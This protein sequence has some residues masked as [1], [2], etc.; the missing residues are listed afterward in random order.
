M[1]AQ[2]I[3]QGATPYSVSYIIS[4]D[5]G[6]AAIYPTASLLA[7]TVAGALQSEIAALTGQLDKLNAGAADHGKIRIR[8]VTGVASA[9]V[10][11]VATTIKW[12]ATGLSAQVTAASAVAIEIR[13]IHG[14]EK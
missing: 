8:L 10:V 3:K 7:D 4:G 9:N 2:F 5:N 11:P 1:A 6:G 14:L 13:L 12:V